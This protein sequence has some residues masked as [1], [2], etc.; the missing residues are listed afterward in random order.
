GDTYLLLFTSIFTS[1]PRQRKIFVGVQQTEWYDSI[2]PFKQ[3][4]SL[5]E[6]MWLKRFAGLI[7]VRDQ[8]TKK[9][10]QQ[11]GFN[12]VE[13]P[14]N[15]MMDC[16]KIHPKNIFPPDREVIGIL[17]G[18]KNE[19]YHNLNIIF[20]VIKL[21]NKENKNL[22]FAVALS[23][24]L[25]L[26]RIIHS[27]NLQELPP[28][29]DRQSY[30]AYTIKDGDKIEIIISQSLFGNIINEACAVIGLS[31]T[32]NEQAAGLGK[33]IFSFWGKGPQITKKFLLA[34][35][36]LLG[37]SLFVF[38]PQPEI[39]VR[40]ICKVIR[41]R[42]LLKKIEQNGKKRMSGRGSISAIAEDIYQYINT[43]NKTPGT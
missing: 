5:P 19:A 6:R 35:K 15:P 27:F 3:H 2:K 7:F 36:K 29:S 20:E 16:F 18:S 32:G 13:S 10:L 11:K 4:Y 42:S 14:G 24:N 25:S 41:D 9:Y 26:S 12:N 33:P 39:I 28:C 30:T 40:E 1:H 43:T 31:G 21:L 22:L 34:Q 38:P 37:P 23:P 8:K 17:P